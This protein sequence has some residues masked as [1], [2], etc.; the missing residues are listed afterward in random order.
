MMPMN[1]SPEN[2]EHLRIEASFAKQAS[3]RI[4]LVSCDP[5][6]SAKSQSRSRAGRHMEEKKGRLLG[7]H[8]TVGRATDA[9]A[10]AAILHELLMRRR[11][12]FED[13]FNKSSISGTSSL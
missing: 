2:P 5:A 13:R 9:Q 11:P 10:H 3:H 7:I 4:E 12:V 8:Q 6:L 1:L